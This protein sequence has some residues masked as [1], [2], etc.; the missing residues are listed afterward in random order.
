MEEVW[1]KYGSQRYGRSL[2]GNSVEEIWKKS[3]EEVWKKEVWGSSRENSGE[4]R[5]FF[6]PVLWR[7]IGQIMENQ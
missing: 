7:K 3:M 2:D 5:L 1:K 6:G 4:N